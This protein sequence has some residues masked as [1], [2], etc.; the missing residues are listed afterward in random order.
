MLRS[1]EGRSILLSEFRASFDLL[2][3]SAVA[4]TVVSPPA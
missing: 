2:K 3:K 1:A 4:T